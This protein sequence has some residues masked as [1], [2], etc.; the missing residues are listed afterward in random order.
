MDRIKR[1]RALAG[2]SCRS[3]TV[4]DWEQFQ[5]IKETKSFNKVLEL[6]YKILANISAL[7]Q[8]QEII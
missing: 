3:Y 7:A 2:I 5:Q 1:R 6:S 8:L 4:D